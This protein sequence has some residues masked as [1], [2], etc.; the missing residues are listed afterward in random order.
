MVAKTDFLM[1]DDE[2]SVA[3]IFKRIAKEEKWSIEH[4]DTGYKALH[5]LAEHPPLVIVL[6]VHL[7]GLDGFQILEYVRA[8]CPDTEVV[9]ITGL[10]KIED[11]VKALKMGAFDYLTKPFDNLEI[12]RSCLR[13]AYE[14]AQ[15]KSRLHYFETDES[16]QGFQGILGRS[17]P[18]QD[19]YH[20][21]QSVSSSA[22]SVLI[23]GESGTGKERVA[24]AI[25][26]TSLRK[27]KPFVVINCSAIPE[28]LLESELFGHVRGAFTGALSD[29]RGLFEEAGEGTVFLDEVGEIPLSIQVK[30]LR[31]LQEKEVRRVG[32]NETISVNVR[33]IAATHR[34]LTDLI[35][36]GQFREDLYY[37]LNVI[38][39]HLP[40]LRERR[41]D[42][43]LL[44]HSFLKKYAKRMDREI[45]EIS[46]DALQLLQN[47]IW[48]GNVRELENVIERCVVLSDGNSIQV[49]DLPPKLNTRNFYFPDIPKTELTELTYQEAKERA[50]EF[51]NKTYLKYLL[52]QSG[53][54][55]SIASLRAGMDRSNFKKI[56]RKYE[57]DLKEFKISDIP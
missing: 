11:S 40:P 37:R 56:I 32:G 29:K 49:K 16:S 33:I 44:A 21:I 10:A 3:E 8:N 55:I 12:V 30:L 28:G 45:H 35:S 5:F 50:L 36:K 7:P 9:V 47:Y 27:D 4:V 13:Q 34:D 41:E 22:A 24:K 57:I 6:D 38:G 2:S 20:T 23:M 46:S 54:N 26:Q 25:H 48:V 14:K 43:P 18:M 1:V 51:F 17:K 42:I 52:E 39:I 53:G 31:V 19:I 15:L